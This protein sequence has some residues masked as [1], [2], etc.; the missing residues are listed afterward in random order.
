MFKLEPGDYD[1]INT[2]LKT[3][4]YPPIVA[5]QKLD[6]D[7]AAM[8]WKDADGNEMPYLGAIGGGLTYS[9]TPT[10]IG[11][12]AIVEFYTGEKL[13]LTDYDW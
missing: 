12:I 5:K 3:V 4:V 1:K 9:F 10:S 7:T 6:P 13:D 2:W 11:L 8:I